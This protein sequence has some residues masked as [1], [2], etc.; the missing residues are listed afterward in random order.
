[1]TAALLRNELLHHLLAS[2]P[3][4]TRTENARAGAL[5][6]VG[7]VGIALLLLQLPTTKIEQP[8]ETIAGPIV[9]LTDPVLAI[10]PAPAPASGATT[11]GAIRA[12]AF[13]PGIREPSRSHS[14]TEMASS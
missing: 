11:G 9:L 3:E 14:S 13:L 12:P 7:H 6:L 10:E 5:A 2:N 4:R 8:V 1:M